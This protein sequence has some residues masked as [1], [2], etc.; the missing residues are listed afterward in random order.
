M[1]MEL[2]IVLGVIGGLI[3]VLLLIYAA[4]YVTVRADEAVIVTGSA[5]GRKHAVTDVTGRKI[6][7]I[8]GGGVFVIPIIQRFERISLLSHKLDVSTPEV[9][10]E[11]G[12]PVEADGVAIIKIG[13]TVED[14]STAAEQFLGKGPKE[15]REEAREVLEGHL[16]AILGTLTV[17]E[18]YKNRDKFAQEVQTVAAKDLKKMGLVIVSFTI[19]DLRDKNGYLAALGVPQIEAVKRNAIISKAEAEKEA[20]I[21]QAEAEQLARQAELLK[22]TH[23]A[24]SE[25]DKELKIA[26]YKLQQDR[27]KAEADM[28][29]DLQKARSAQEVTQEEMQIEIVR[30]QKQIEIEEKEIARREKQYDAEVKKKADA[31]RYAIEQAAEAEKTR[32]LREAEADKAKGAAE[33]DV[34]RLKGLAEAE[35]K[36]KLAEAFEKFG[37]AAILDVIVKML[38]E[39]AGKIAEPISAIDK[40]TVIDAGNGNGNGDG[41][42][43]VS[44]YVT[45]LMAQLPETLKDVS[46]F[47]LNEV[48]LNFAK[49]YEAKEK[50]KEEVITV[51]KL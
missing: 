16:R 43:R 46:G 9:Y 20:R 50:E 5:L 35:A 26:E 37:Q 51:E 48:L 28:A 40:I 15:L 4:R 8:R 42:A 19:K 34:I 27:A 21:K 41:A 7:I 17:E 33:A 3:F 25:K 11:Q 32:K 38:P 12:V 31:D 44:N 24:E 47:D 6:K 18:I 22:E 10:T 23:I 14:I 39:L 45:K 29:Y 36:E 13:G 1:G 49:Q 2:L 30:K